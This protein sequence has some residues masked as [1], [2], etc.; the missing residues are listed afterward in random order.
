MKLKIK[1]LFEKKSNVFFKKCS[2][3]NCNKSAVYKAP[4]SRDDLKSYIWFCEE[5]IKEYNKSWNYCKNMSEDEIENHI[6][7]DAIGWRP[8]WDFSS[9]KINLKNFQ[10]IFFN[11]FNFF[12]NKKKSKVKNMG[13]EVRNSLVILGI[14]HNDF[15]FK[16][17]ETKYRK[18]VKKYH[19]DKNKGDKECEEKLKKINNAYTILKKFYSKKKLNN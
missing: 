9:R 14:D 16:E 19:P 8:T 17:I 6:K 7:L 5:H 10:K 11:Y 13:M 18:L 3:E 4:K 1:S 2:K 15:S 12:N